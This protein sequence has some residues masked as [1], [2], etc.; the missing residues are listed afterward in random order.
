MSV[1]ADS[2]LRVL[3]DIEDSL[4]ASH[5]AA[6]PVWCCKSDH[7]SERLHQ[8]IAPGGQRDYHH[9][10]VRDEDGHIR[11]VVYRDDLGGKRGP[12]RKNGRLIGVDHKFE[13]SRPLLDAI[14][15]LKNTGFLLVTS[16]E[17]GQPDGVS[18]II[19]HADLQKLPVRLLLF[20]RLSELEATLREIVTGSDWLIR[21]DCSNERKYAEG[22][23]Q[24]HN[25]GE[26]DLPLEQYLNL[27][28]LVA[29]A[30]RLN[31]FVP[32][33]RAIED[34]L[35]SL[36]AVRNH[37]AHGLEFGNGDTPSPEETVKAVQDAFAIVE[38]AIRSVVS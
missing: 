30:Q 19:N 10:P 17:S 4:T 32:Q 38:W 20:A 11:T 27:K 7:D 23:R 22:E 24:R 16:L 12:A 5:I 9:V 33:E 8:E 26:E 29:V 25:K 13:A 3:A 37:I 34:R 21:G 2:F 18:G 14:V 35:T 15:R 6:F 36:R 1:H 31:R 28:G